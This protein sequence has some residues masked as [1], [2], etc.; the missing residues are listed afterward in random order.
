MSIQC[1]G[2]T[3]RRS[4]SVFSE[5]TSVS[6]NFARPTLALHIP[7]YMTDINISREGNGKKRANFNSAEGTFW[8][9]EPPRA[10]QCDTAAKAPLISL[11]AEWP[12]KISLADEAGGRGGLRCLKCT[13]FVDR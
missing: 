5:L 11:R 9:S 3:L 1:P 10:C 7:L 12:R 8:R 6:V 2:Y 4:C 13:Q